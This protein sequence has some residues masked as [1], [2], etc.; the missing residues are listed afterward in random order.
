MNNLHKL[1]EKI[2]ANER[3]DVNEGLAL[4]RQAD[5]LTLASLA[6]QKRFY[7]HPERRVTYVVD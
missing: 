1:I 7:Y 3:I 5:F 2:K 6:N 4:F